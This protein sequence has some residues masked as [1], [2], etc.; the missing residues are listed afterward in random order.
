[1]ESFMSNFKKGFFIIAGTIT[2]LVISTLIGTVVLRY[3]GGASTGHVIGYEPET[4]V[5]SL[6]IDTKNNIVKL[7]PADDGKLNVTYNERKNENI[8]FSYTGSELVVTR[9]N[10]GFFFFGFGGGSDT[11]TVYIPEGFSGVDVKTTNA[12]AEMDGLVLAGSLTVSTNNGSII[13]TAPTVTGDLKLSTTNAMVKCSGAAVTGNLEIRS[14]N[15]TID[16]SN[17]SASGGA[18]FK[19]TNSRMNILS[20]DVAKLEAS[21]T[22]GA[23]RVTDLKSPNGITLKSTNG[24]I[25]G[26][27]RGNKDDFTIKAHTTNA[28]NNL[29]D[30]PTGNIPLTVNTTNAAI[31]IY[32]NEENVETAK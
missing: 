13:C 28:E 10:K 3:F 7:Y 4:A 31:N 9:Q 30:K 27:I 32:F 12:A 5:T 15:G 25:T 19:T 14:T 11:I 2:A 22:N 23:I 16:T 8:K 24:T 1:M 26:D 20:M 6:R 29:E 18:V 17:G 21:T